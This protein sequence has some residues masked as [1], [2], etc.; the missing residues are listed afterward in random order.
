M[1]MADDILSALRFL[2]DLQTSEGIKYRIS[3]GPDGNVIIDGGCETPKG[4]ATYVAAITERD[5]ERDG[6]NVIATKAAIRIRD[7]FRAHAADRP[8]NQ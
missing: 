8:E 7:A 3:V 6:W 1:T 4:W 5:I 2:R